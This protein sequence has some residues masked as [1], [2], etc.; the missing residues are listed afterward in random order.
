MK[1]ILLFSQMANSF[2]VYF[3]L[4]FPFRITAYT[5]SQLVS[6]WS[7][8]LGFTPSPMDSSSL[9]RPSLF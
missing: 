7:S 4:T 8:L 3:P 6:V 2:G 9:P 1:V 5:A